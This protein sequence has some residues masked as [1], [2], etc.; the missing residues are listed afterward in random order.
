MP[1]LSHV[2]SSIL[3][4]FSY[5]PIH[6]DF[7]HKRV[8]VPHAE[9]AAR[10][11]TEH[12]QRRTPAPVPT[13]PSSAQHSSSREASLQPT[14]ACPARHLGAAMHPRCSP[15][16]SLPR[17]M[18]IFFRCCL[19]LAPP[20][21]SWSWTGDPGRVLNTKP[22]HHDPPSHDACLPSS[23]PALCH[24]PCTALDHHIFPLSHP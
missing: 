6:L 3:S 20:V 14:G 22:Q 4:A 17:E 18:L 12:E 13:H 8:S 10:A 24:W 2:F 15:L 19:S 21:W 23:T 5:M 1:L 11:L 9:A 16:P 7:Q